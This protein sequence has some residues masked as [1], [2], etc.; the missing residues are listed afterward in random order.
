VIGRDHDE[1][2]DRFR[3]GRAIRGLRQRRGWRQVDLAERSGLAR[4][5]I[6]RIEVGQIGRIAYDDLVAAATAVDGQLAFDFRWRGEG[7]DR[8]IDEAHAGV[9]DQLVEVYRMAR[10]EVAVEVSFSIFG[11]RGSI[12]VFAWHPTVEVV[13]V[14]EV[15][16]SVPEA[17][18]TVIG[19][20]RKSR[21]APQIAREHGW[22]CKGVAR[23]LVIRDTSTSRRRVAEH[24]ELFRSAFP[25]GGRESLDWIR[26]PTRRPMSGLIFLPDSRGAGTRKRLV[27]RKR[28]RVAS[29]RTNGE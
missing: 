19:V 14:N 16:A 8:L 5:V 11:E 26:Y 29:P 3:F 1:T 4:S 22:A 9:V 27:A 12:D 21:L 20:D 2:M 17:G 25:V 6:G 13:A 28:V 10:W 15:K 7:L 23:F 24:E 18:G